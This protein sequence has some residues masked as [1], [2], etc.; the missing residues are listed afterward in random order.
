MTSK[1]TL[2]ATIMAMALLV[3]SVS[4]VAAQGNGG[5]GGGNPRPG[6]GRPVQGSPVQGRSAQGQTGGR[7]LQAL[8]PATDAEP[9]AEIVDAM[10]AGILDEYHALAVYEAVIDQFGAVRPFTNIMRAEQKHIDAWAAMFERY[11]L[12]VPAAPA[13]V[14]VPEFESVA[15]A[16]ALGAAAEV[17]NFD[18]YD[19]MGEVF[20]GY[21][22]LQQVATVLRDAS[23]YNHLPA[24]ERCAATA[25]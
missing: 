7:L 1:R 8:P 11:D 16:C 2:M 20:A 14:A 4:A 3:L 18:L 24:F 6:Q 15:A 17:A 9:T 21:P 5:N 13:A 22:D 25:R 10:T 23:E 12:P 19:E